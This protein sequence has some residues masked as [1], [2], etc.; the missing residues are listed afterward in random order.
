MKKLKNSKVMEFAPNH[1]ASQWQSRD[2]SSVPR[3]VCSC[4]RPWTGGSQLL[5]PVRIT[6]GDY[7]LLQALSIKSDS[8]RVAPE[9]LVIAKD[10]P[11]D[12]LNSWIGDCV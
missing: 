12:S 5:Q 2:G 6:E 3:P 1:T 8:L 4:Y 10:P 11:S 9:G 7:L